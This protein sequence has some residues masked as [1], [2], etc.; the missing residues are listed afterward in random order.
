ML[1]NNKV[2]IGGKKK[3]YFIDINSYTKEKEINFDNS[4]F[5]IKKF[6]ENLLMIGDDKG[7]IS[8]FNINDNELKVIKKIHNKTIY[9]MVKFNRKLVS[10][11]FDKVIKFKTIE[12]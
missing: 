7:Y 3:I 10:G 11:G 2:I 1:Y 6:K 12:N 4:I 9:A 8:S 5:S